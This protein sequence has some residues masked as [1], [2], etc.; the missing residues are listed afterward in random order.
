MLRLLYQ[1]S[2]SRSPQ[3]EIAANFDYWRLDLYG[4]HAGGCET[5][6]FVLGS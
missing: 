1:Q 4:L 5:D 6:F 2:R 3:E